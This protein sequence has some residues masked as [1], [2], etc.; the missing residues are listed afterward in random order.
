MFF[1]LSELYGEACRVHGEMWKA[2][3][4]RVFAA[5]QQ[6]DLLMVPCCGRGGIYRDHDE[7]QLFFSLFL[8][9]FSPLC[10]C[11]C[12]NVL[13]ILLLWMN[14]SVKQWEKTAQFLVFV[15]F[16]GAA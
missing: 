12:V 16:L 6:S 1:T 2:L 7:T 14:Q 4:V 8:F 11:M 3:R 13:L 10:V 5:V 9:S 15:C